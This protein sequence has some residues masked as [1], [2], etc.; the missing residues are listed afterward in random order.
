[1][2]VLYVFYSLAEDLKIP[3]PAAMALSIR[4]QSLPTS[5]TR[6]PSMKPMSQGARFSLTGQSCSKT[7]RSPNTTFAEI[8]EK[9][10]A[11]WYYRDNGAVVPPPQVMSVMNAVVDAQLP[12]KL[13]TKPEFLDSFGPSGIRLG[14]NNDNTLGKKTM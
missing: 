1:M 12:I 6:D 9:N 4:R 3:N 14:Q 5:R 13:S 8:N 7:N 11:G 2:P 10:G